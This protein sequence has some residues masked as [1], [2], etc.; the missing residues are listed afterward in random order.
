MET[1]FHLNA[2]ELNADFLEAVKKLFGGKD[3]IISVAAETD[4][5]EYLLS[6]P[7]RKEML[8]KSM[9]EAENGQLV[10]VNPADFRA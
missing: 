3:I 6:D 7:A 9:Q 5:T 1:T 2:S 8:L 4:A 10:S